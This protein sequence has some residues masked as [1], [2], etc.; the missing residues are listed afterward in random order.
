MCI[1]FPGNSSLNVVFPTNRVKGHK[2]SA[3]NVIVINEY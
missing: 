1:I 2:M 3:S